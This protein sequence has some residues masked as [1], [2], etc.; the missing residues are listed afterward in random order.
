MTTA[1]ARNPSNPIG[2]HMPDR[3]H[4]SKPTFDLD[5]LWGI[6]L[7]RGRWPRTARLVREIAED[8]EACCLDSALG[9]VRCRGEGPDRAAS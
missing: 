7:R 4:D 6:D 5:Q 1:A 9:D 2:G 3:Q 8:Y